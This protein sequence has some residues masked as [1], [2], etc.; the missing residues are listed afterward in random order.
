MDLKFYVFLG[1]GGTLWANVSRGNAY[2][3]ATAVLA[4]IQYR[5][6]SSNQR[7]NSSLSKSRETV[8]FKLFHK[9]PLNHF[10]RR[11]ANKT[12]RPL[13]SLLSSFLLYSSHRISKKKIHREVHYCTVYLNSHHI[14]FLS[15]TEMPQT[16]IKINFNIRNEKSVPMTKA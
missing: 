2:P 15:H 4:C 16:R 8:P 3:E 9:N 14:S 6:P 1:K 10:G 12:F 7:T 5:R 11:T 13:T